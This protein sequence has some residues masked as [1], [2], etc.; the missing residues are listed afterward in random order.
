MIKWDALTPE[1]EKSL[2]ALRR[3]LECIIWEGEI[4]RGLAK[5]NE[6]PPPDEIQQNVDAAVRRMEK[7]CRSVLEAQHTL[8]GVINV[9]VSSWRKSGGAEA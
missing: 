7:T 3:E 5:G 4:T 6:G 8:Y 9:K 1:R 2:K